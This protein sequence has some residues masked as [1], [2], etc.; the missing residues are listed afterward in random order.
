MTGKTKGAAKGEH[1]KHQKNYN[2]TEE[3]RQEA[4]ITRPVNRKE[5]ILRVLGDREM[6]AREIAY[7]LGFNERNAAAPR[8]TEMRNEGLLEVV[9]KKRD[10]V[11]GKNVALWRVV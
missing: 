2:I 1:H 7:A 11:T 6:T 10:F 8:L 4:Y 5:D 3:T 9:G